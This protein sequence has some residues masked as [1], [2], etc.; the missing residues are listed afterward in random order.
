[1]FMHTIH[2]GSSYLH[3]S[4]NG[5]EDEQAYRSY[6]DADKGGGTAEETP[7]LKHT[8]VSIQ[9]IV[10]TSIYPMAQTKENHL[11]LGTLLVNYLD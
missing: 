7:A 6:E 1:M 8:P 3:E 4:D 9:S 5:A 2:V 10:R 11:C